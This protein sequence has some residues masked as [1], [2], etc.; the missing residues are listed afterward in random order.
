MDTNATAAASSSRKVSVRGQDFFD[1]SFFHSEAT[2][3][4]FY[5]FIAELKEMCEAANPTPTHEFLKDLIVQRK[6]IR[7]YT[8]NIDSLE[9]RVGLQ[10]SI[11]AKKIAEAISA[12]NSAAPITS[13]MLLPAS[14]PATPS[15]HH[16]P[17]VGLHGTLDRLCCTVCKMSFVYE[18]HESMKN[19]QSPD[20]HNCK[21]RIEARKRNGQRSI[22]GGVL[23]PDIV[24]YNEP[25][26]Q[27]EAIAEYITAD[28]SRRPTMLLV[29]GT[30]LKVVGLKRLIKD[31]SKAIHANSEDGLVVY[32]NK[33][34]VQAKS[35][36]RSI[37]NYELIGECDAWVSHLRAEFESLEAQSATSACK[38]TAAKPKPFPGKKEAPPAPTA[39]TPSRPS[40]KNAR[41]ESFFK[42]AKTATSSAGG[43]ALS[44]TRAV[45]DAEAP[46]AC[47]D[48]EN[49][50][51]AGP[52]TR[53]KTRQQVALA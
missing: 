2:R 24:L 46:P 34:G 11:S 30:S 20:C 22:R 5:K 31:I 35:E 21:E 50:V 16:P 38:A 13:V 4:F 6:A 28:I 7:W 12:P 3:P 37:F 32:L 44:R 51:N 19:G 27:G 41:I 52:R 48:K 47:D 15:R 25:N 45:Q 29:I 14:S 42:H 43:K 36:W 26:P 23:R 53:S 8:Q 49:L 17:V 1:A 10:T 9:E 39:K 40:T 33:T 18:Q